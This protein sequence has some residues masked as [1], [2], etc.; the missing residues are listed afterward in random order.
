MDRQRAVGGDG[1]DEPGNV[2][3][4]HGTIEGQDHRVGLR[5]DRLTE[6]HGDRGIAA[7]EQAGLRG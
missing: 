4:P 5:V 1:F 6:L 2:A 7:P 3:I